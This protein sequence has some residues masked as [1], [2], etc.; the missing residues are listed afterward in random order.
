MTLSHTDQSTLNNQQPAQWRCH[1]P[2][3]PRWTTNTQHNDAVTHRSV[4]AEQL[5]T[6]TMALLHTAQSTL[7]N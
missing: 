3:S 1:T 5:T 4:H 6:S 2:I 7:N